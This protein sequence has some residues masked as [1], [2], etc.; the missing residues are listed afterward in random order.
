MVSRFIVVL[1]DVVM[2]LSEINWSDRLGFNY[3]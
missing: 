2:V 3:E 1:C